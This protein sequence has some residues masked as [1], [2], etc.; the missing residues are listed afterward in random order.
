MSATSKNWNDGQVRREAALSCFAEALAAAEPAAA[1]R[2]AVQRNGNILTVGSK[3]YDLTQFDRVFVAGAGKAGTAMAQALE[4]VLGD[5]LTDGV[6]VVKRG[7]AGPTRS[8]RLFEAA[9][10]VPD[11]EGRRAG[12]AL[13]QLVGSATPKDLVLCLISGGGSALLVAPAGDITLADQQT[14]T[15]LLLRAGCTINEINAVRKHCSRIKGGKLAQAANGAEIATLILSDV[16]GS[17]LDVI[18]SGP[19]VPDPTTFGDALRVVDRYELRGQLPPRI[20]LHLEAGARGDVAETPKP[21]DPLFASAQTVLVGSIGQVCDLAA[22]FARSQGLHP[23]ILSTFAE[24]EAREAA[25]LLA[26]VIREVEANNRP[27]PRP[28]C[29]IL[30]GETTVVVRGDGLGGRCQELA[31]AAAIALEGDSTATLAALATDGGDGPTDAAGAIVDGHTAELAR[32]KGISL[33]DALRRNDA[34]HVLDQLGALVRT[35]PTGT[36]VN[37]LVLAIIA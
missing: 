26:S 24:G 28:A 31:L 13:L 34:Y 23:I 10:P 5:F 2:R 8:I 33:G 17:P 22:A 29:V 32:S 16:V 20:R 35:G 1:I 14:M 36:N 6:V 7:G 18:A 9:H 37:D 19:T 30:G 12:E 15:E 25:R 21:G 11:E 27:V 3:Q 4:E